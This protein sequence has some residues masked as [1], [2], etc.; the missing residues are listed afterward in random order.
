MQERENM[1]KAERQAKRQAKQLESLTELHEQAKFRAMPM[2]DMMEKLRKRLA[3]AKRA[4][5]S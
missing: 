1:T 5:R 3:K 2:S 4:G